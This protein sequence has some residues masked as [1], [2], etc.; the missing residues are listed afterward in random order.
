MCTTEAK[1][2]YPGIAEPL[3]KL[4]VAQLV[5]KYVPLQNSMVHNHIHRA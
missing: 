1:N 4:P 5:K 2:N 3:K